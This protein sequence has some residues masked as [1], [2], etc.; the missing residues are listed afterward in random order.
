MTVDNK[1][2]DL[3]RDQVPVTLPGAA[4]VADAVGQMVERRVGSVLVTQ[5]GSRTGALLGIFT[6]R[7]LAARVV[8]AR[9]DPATT[10]L[11][12]VMTPSPEVVEPGVTVREALA[13][14]EARQFRHLP[15]V[16]GKKL[17]G[18]VSIRDISAQIRN[19]LEAD[20][21]DYRGFV[22]PT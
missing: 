14:M 17:Q 10:L 2:G 1:V 7:D 13:L 20:I 9:R 8:A 21:E 4:S 22:K 19:Q 11:V 5:N 18:V 15:V 6:E 16:K 12:D 3:I